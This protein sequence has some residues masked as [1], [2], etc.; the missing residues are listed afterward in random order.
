LVNFQDSRDEE[1]NLLLQEIEENEEKKKKEKQ[2][3]SSSSGHGQIR[4]RE[5]NVVSVKAKKNYPQFVYN[6]AYVGIQAGKCQEYI[7][8]GNTSLL[9]RDERFKE[10]MDRPYAVIP[11]GNHKE[12]GKAYLLISPKW[13]GFRAGWL[14]SQTET[15]NIFRVDRYAAWSGLVPDDLK[16]DF[17]LSP[18]Y[19][20]IKILQNGDYLVGNEF[21]LEDAS[22]RW[23]YSMDTKNSKKSR[24]MEMA[25]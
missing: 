17:D 23:R 21:E 10:F 20:S 12:E 15:Y 9:T 14:E 6:R 5:R 18:R 3:P 7:I 11:Q 24:I 19:S 1:A 16:E 2:L 25:Y 22:I 13:T 4:V 8:D